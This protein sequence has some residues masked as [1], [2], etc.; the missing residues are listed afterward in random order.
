MKK[1]KNHKNCKNYKNYKN[2]KKLQHN[3]IAEELQRNES[4]GESKV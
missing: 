3:E 4:D 1:Y 2:Y